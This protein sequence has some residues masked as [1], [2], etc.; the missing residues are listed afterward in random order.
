MMFSGRG[1]K[2]ETGILHE[3]MGRVQELVD[4]HRGFVQELNRKLDDL[5]ARTRE[6]LIKI[7]GRLDD[8]EDEA[9]AAANRENN[10]QKV[11]DLATKMREMMHKMSLMESA[12]ATQ[13]KHLDKEL[14]RIRR[15][16]DIIENGGRYPGYC[17][18]AVKGPEQ[19]YHTPSF[20]SHGSFTG[21]IVE[22][23]SRHNNY[24]GVARHCD[25]R[26]SGGYRR[27]L[28]SLEMER[29]LLLRQLHQTHHL[30]HQRDDLRKDLINFR[31][32]VNRLLNTLSVAQD[33]HGLKR[34]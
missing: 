12:R 33:T 6:A 16:M 23:A 4:S 10:A 3:Q 25:A 28:D 1:S 20:Q 5:N 26:D 30:F 19:H 22:G 18:N 13:R 27:Q 15:F 2:T 24:Q 29:Q 7:T 9:E 17:G 31:A 32:E 34:H 14:A 11:D 8:L 21:D